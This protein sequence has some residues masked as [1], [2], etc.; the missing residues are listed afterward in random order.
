M[1]ASIDPTP[2]IAS[3]PNLRDVGGHATPDGRRVRTGLLY[4]SAELSQLDGADA[5]AFAALGIRSVYDLRTRQERELA[6]D[7]LPRGSELVCLDL[8]ADSPEASPAELM[9]LLADPPAATA[10]LGRDGSARMFEHKYRELVTLQSA[11]RGFGRLFRDLGSATHRPALVHCTTG[12]DRTGWAAAALQLL[13]GVP[14][15]TV[16]DDFLRSNEMLGPWMRPFLDGFAARGGDPAVLVPMLGVSSSYLDT[17]LAE[18]ATT[19]GSIEGYFADGL[20][21]QPSE[22][23]ALREAFLEVG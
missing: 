7:R 10:A 3:L 15:E 11:R 5:V 23:T 8:F 12:K 22:L 20:G 14:D 16:R 18:M 2:H 4:R 19:F 9:A 13:L 6:P 1:S 17:A 21:L